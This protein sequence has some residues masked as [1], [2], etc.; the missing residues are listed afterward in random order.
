MFDQNLPISHEI[1]TV[2]RYNIQTMFFFLNYTE[3]HYFADELEKG[4]P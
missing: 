4:L 1:P 3:D 2:V